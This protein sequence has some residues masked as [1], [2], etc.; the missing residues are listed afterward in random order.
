MKCYFC[1]R[2]ATLYCDGKNCDRPICQFHAQT[3][4][5]YCVGRGRKSNTIDVCPDCLNSKNH[6]SL[7]K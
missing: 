4:A 5:M 3:L 2:K 1:H 6:W 7:Q